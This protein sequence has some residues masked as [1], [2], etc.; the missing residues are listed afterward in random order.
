MVLAYES[1]TRFDLNGDGTIS[2][3]EMKEVLQTL[4][5]ASWP[6]RKVERF[7]Q[8]IDKNRDGSIDYA[9]LLDWI[10]SSATDAQKAVI[11]KA[12]DP[13]QRLAAPKR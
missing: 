9:E 13:P 2:L 7:L 10:F 11:Q 8:T 5:K 4:D 12:V 1:F 6:D 3:G